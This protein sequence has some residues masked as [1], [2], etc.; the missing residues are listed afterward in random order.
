[1]KLIMKGYT[2]PQDIDRRDKS[3]NGVLISK[4]KLFKFCR[5]CPYRERKCKPIMV[6]VY[7]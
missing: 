7:Q 6:K 1:M 2:C 3:I 4:K 5:E